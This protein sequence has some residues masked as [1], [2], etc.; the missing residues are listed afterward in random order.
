MFN[1]HNLISGVINANVVVAGVCGVNSVITPKSFLSDANAAFVG[2]LKI[3]QGIRVLPAVP[4]VKP[5]NAEV[6][7]DILNSNVER[8]EKQLVTRDVEL[9]N[10]LL[11][12][13][14]R[15]FGCAF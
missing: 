15:I 4:V 2:S 7:D 10:L 1:R 9:F 3:E 11:V 8:I 12:A 5:A 6:L 13:L 14:T